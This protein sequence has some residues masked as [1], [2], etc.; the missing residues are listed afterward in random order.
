VEKNEKNNV[1]VNLGKTFGYM[2]KSE[3]NPEEPP[4][5]AGQKYHFVIKDVLQQ[6]KG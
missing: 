1:T 6:S 2:P 4:L 5:V 3:A